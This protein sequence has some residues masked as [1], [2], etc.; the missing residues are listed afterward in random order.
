MKNK[1]IVIASIVFTIG[2]IIWSA[3]KEQNRFN[4]LKNTINE[5]AVFVKLLKETSTDPAAGEFKYMMNDVVY[6]FRERGDFSALNLG[7]SV[8]IEVSIKDHSIARVLVV[9]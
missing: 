2:V 7:D 8:I 5:K 4:L 3:V 9:E 6:T 1:T